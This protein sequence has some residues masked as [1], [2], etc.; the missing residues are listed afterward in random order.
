[1]ETDKKNKSN[2]NTKH[3]KRTW[4]SVHYCSYSEQYWWK[5]LH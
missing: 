2:S 5:L 3:L 1:M 4:K